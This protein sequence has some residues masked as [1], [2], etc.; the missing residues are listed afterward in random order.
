MSL[1]WC[2]LCQVSPSAESSI[3]PTHLVSFC[4]Y[5]LLETGAVLG[6]SSISNS[7][8]L[9]GGILGRLSGKISE[10]SHTTSIPSMLFALVWCSALRQ[11]TSWRCKVTLPYTEE[12]KQIS[13]LAISRIALCSFIQ[14]IPRMMSIPCP[15]QTMRWVRKT[16]PANSSGTSLAICLVTT[17]APG[18]DNHVRW[19]GDYKWQLCLFS[20]R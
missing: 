2:N 9:S 5:G 16:Y 1:A 14:L 20:T 3:L 15:S 12:S 19:L 6:C 10:N 8:S 17:W 18:G 7:M 11:T 4:V 13:H